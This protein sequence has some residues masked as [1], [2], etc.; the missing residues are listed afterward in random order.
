ME[1]QC[2]LYGLSHSCYNVTKTLFYTPQLQAVNYLNKD[3]DNEANPK[4]TKHG[5]ISAC[6]RR[7]PL[8]SNKNYRLSYINTPQNHGATM[9]NSY[10]HIPQSPPMPTQDEERRARH[11]ALRR[12]MLSGNYEE[13][14]EH[15]PPSPFLIR[16]V[17]AWDL[18]HMSL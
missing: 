15:E 16:Q 18:R 7:A 4:P 10:L 3:V 5:R 6:N 13:D 2:V 8:W 14:L 9:N 17:S 1:K 12:R 11:T